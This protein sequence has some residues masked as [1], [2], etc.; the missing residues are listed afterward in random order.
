MPLSLAPSQWEPLIAT[1]N[2]RYCTIVL[3]GPLLGVVGILEE[4]GRPNYLVRGL[5]S[6]SLKKKLGLDIVSEKTDRG[7][8]YRIGESHPAAQ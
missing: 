4:R 2:R 8:C 1:L 3:G 7:R 6:G 5:I